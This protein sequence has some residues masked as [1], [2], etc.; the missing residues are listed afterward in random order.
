MELSTVIFF[1]LLLCGIQDVC[2]AWASFAKLPLR[3]SLVESEINTFKRTALN[4]D[5]K[6]INKFKVLESSLKEE[7]TTTFLPPL[8]K[9]LVKQ[10][11]IDIMNEDYI[12][13]I[14]TGHVLKVVDRLKAKVQNTET[15]VKVLA[16]QL[17]RVERDR[18][19]Y[20]KSLRK[21][22]RRLTKDIR[23]L[24]LRGAGMLQSE[25][26]Q[27]ND[28]LFATKHQI[29]GLK[30]DLMALNVSCWKRKDAKESDVTERTLTTPSLSHVSSTTPTTMYP[31]TTTA[32][33]DPSPSKTV[34]LTPV[35]PLA[36]QD[37][38]LQATP[39][40]ATDRDLYSASE[41]GDLE[42]V[43]RILGA[44]HVDINTR[45]DYSRTPVMVAALEG[46]RDVVEL[47]VDRGADVS[48]VD[49]N[50]TNVLHWACFGGDLE[51]V[52]LILSLN[53]VDINARDNRGRTAADWAKLWG[54]QPLLALLV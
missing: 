38:D 21:L 9:P 53:A 13:N 29:V 34:P 23:A 8:I 19:T 27:T 11:I 45:G 7:M 44:G 3:V 35:T 25:L 15:Q 20:R 47:L 5:V 2:Y 37:S 52:K 26:N 10:A 28:D 4:A 16:Q 6:L 39:S 14:I 33:T 22:R 30:E 41:D 54:H 32:S 17:R 42:R 36:T 49:V 1:G 46:H 18:D 40:P 43:K 50:G 51:I 48:L 31:G 12:G 24:H